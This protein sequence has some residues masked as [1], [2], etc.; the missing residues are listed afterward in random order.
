MTRRTLTL[1]CDWCG[2]MVRRHLTATE[3]PA[4]IHPQLRA[5]LEAEG[6]LLRETDTCPE[7]A[8]VPLTIT[9]EIRA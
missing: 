3:D 6:W 2:A 5:E 8:P 9:E 7:C 1:T 4:V